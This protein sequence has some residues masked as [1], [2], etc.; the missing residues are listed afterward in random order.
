M[1]YEWRRR[2]QWWRSSLPRFDLGQHAHDR[3]TALRALV[4]EP[5]AIAR[6]RVLVVKVAVGVVRWQ[7]GGAEGLVVAAVLKAE[8]ADVVVDEA[9]RQAKIH[10]VSHHVHVQKLC[11]SIPV[12]SQVHEPTLHW[13]Q[14]LAPNSNS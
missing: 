5:R 14:L 13:L 10:C 11:F 1:A 6:R 7:L 4:D 8:A 2:G 12:F 3:R 9:R